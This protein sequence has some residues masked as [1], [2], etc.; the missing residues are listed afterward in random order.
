MPEKLKE[1]INAVGVMTE[2]W[3]MTYKNFIDHGYSNTEA[4]THTR[5]FMAAFMI[6]TVGQ[7]A[8]NKEEN[9]NG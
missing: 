1:L 4:L 3:T 9:N 5:E 2:L 6:A 7:A 8:K